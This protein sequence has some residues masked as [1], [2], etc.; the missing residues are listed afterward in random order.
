MTT[1]FSRRENISFFCG[2]QDIL[3]IVCLD[4]FSLQGPGRKDST[5]GPLE[6][7]M[8]A[9]FRVIGQNEYT[10]VPNDVKL[11]LVLGTGRNSDAN[12]LKNGNL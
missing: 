4:G 8:V 10:F 12:E 5:S 9:C 6:R 7:A 11:I 3:R 2:S 1:L